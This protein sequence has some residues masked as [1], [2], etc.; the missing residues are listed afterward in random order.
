MSADGKITLPPAL[1]DIIKAYAGIYNITCD[2]KI[3][4]TFPKTTLFGLCDSFKI[5]YSSLDEKKLLL[6][7]LADH[8]MNENQWLQIHTEI[9]KKQA[10]INERIWDSKFSVG[11]EVLILKQGVKGKSTLYIR[12][13]DQCKY[14]V[15][16]ELS[17]GSGKTVVCSYGQRHDT[18]I[19]EDNV[20]KSQLGVVH[21][22]NKKSVVV[23]PYKFD[24]TALANTG[25]VTT[26]LYDPISRN[27]IT[28][29]KYDYTLELFYD[30][31]NF[32]KNVT[33][34]GGD[35]IP[36]NNGSFDMM[37]LYHSGFDIVKKVIPS[38]ITEINNRERIEYRVKYNNTKIKKKKL[39]NNV[40]KSM[41]EI[42]HLKARLNELEI[43]VENGKMDLNSMTLQMSDMIN[44]SS[45]FHEKVGCGATVD[46]PDD[47]ELW[48]T[49]ASG[50]YFYRNPKKGTYTTKRPT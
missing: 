7:S 16:P 49:G 50:E 12:P 32:E 37:V 33:L 24:S 4:R 6:G 25:G 15:G 36:I 11:D 17:P 20:F 35:L 10:R 43:I 8:N 3:A 2:W 13:Q 46:L 38:Y 1:W 14:I 44:K 40:A 41:V 34:S 26:H 31:N 18:W 42:K 22:I 39:I 19:L 45:R 28:A 47:W 23:K 29:K 48:Q 27:L 9:K 30:K 5:N 21:K